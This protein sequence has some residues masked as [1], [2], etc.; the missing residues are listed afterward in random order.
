MI[1]FASENNERVL[2]L[3]LSRRDTEALSYRLSDCGKVFAQSNEQKL[4]TVIQ[5]FKEHDDAILISDGAW[6][7]V[8]LPGMVRHLVI[9]RLPFTPPNTLEDQIRAEWLSNHG[10][11]QKVIDNIIYSISLSTARKKFRQGFGRAIRG[12]NDKSTIWISD[13]R[14]ALRREFQTILPKRFTH[15]KGLKPSALENAYV[16]SNNDFSYDA[17]I[18]Q[19]GADWSELS[20]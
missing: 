16:W 6:E 14:F 8:D 18:D 4:S 5:L 19:N 7:G 11:S 20:W 13:P 15:S 17:M 9:T 12:P 1:R 10:Y 2:V 3:T